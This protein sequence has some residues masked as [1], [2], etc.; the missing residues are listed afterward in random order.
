MMRILIFGCLISLLGCGESTSD[1]DATS[2]P[3]CDAD[4]NLQN[5]PDGPLLS[6]THQSECETVIADGKNCTSSGIGCFE[7]QPGCAYACAAVVG[8]LEVCVDGDT[9]GG[10]DGAG[11]DGGDGTSD[12]SIDGSG[13]ITPC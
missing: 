13:E 12:G 8:D 6:P 9:A 10:S 2:E 3:N 1:T 5:C 4:L 11:A 7:T